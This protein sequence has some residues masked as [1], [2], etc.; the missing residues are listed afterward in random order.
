[1]AQQNIY[2]FINEY[3]I[4]NGVRASYNSSINT[5]DNSRNNYINQINY[6][7]DINELVINYI[8]YNNFYTELHHHR[9]KK[10]ITF[11]SDPKFIGEQCSICWDNVENLET[12]AVTKC[13]SKPHIFHKNCILS[14]TKTSSS[15]PNCRSPL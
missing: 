2:Q 9:E 15:C 6:I 5:I 1:M 4:F 13:S 3:D 11:T 8:N 12:M 10:S 14:W 7:H